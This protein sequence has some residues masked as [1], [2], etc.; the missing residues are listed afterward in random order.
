VKS[1]GGGV[2]LYVSY[3][4]QAE[5]IFPDNYQNFEVLWILVHVNRKPI[6]VITV[7]FPPD[8]R[9]SIELVN[10]IT[11]TIDCLISTYPNVIFILGGDFNSL[12]IKLITNHS[13]LFEVTDFPTRGKSCIDHIF[14]SEPCY[15]TE[16]FPVKSTIMTD[17]LA[18][19]AATMPEPSKSCLFSRSSP[20]L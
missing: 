13:H 17:H 12:D 7:Y 6:V 10:H 20:D 9:N 18:I 15:F 8:A 16:V 2:C 3:S 1:S 11:D 14:V 4:L 5:Q 19:V